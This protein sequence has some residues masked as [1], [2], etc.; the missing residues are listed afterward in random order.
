MRLDEFHKVIK[1][2]TEAIEDKLEMDGFSSG[3]NLEFIKE[4]VLRYTRL[5]IDSKYKQDSDWM[6]DLN[7][8]P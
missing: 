8:L 5:M 2:T 6:E 4:V 7:N 3:R 1:Y